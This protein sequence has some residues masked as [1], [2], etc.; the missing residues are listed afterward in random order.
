MAAA[1]EQIPGALMFLS[2]HPAGADRKAQIAGLQR[3]GSVALDAAQW[4]ALRN[5][6]AATSENSSPVGTE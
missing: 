2:T 6:C 3:E 4:Q 1:G 5:V